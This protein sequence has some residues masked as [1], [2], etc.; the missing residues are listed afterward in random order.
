MSPLLIEEMGSALLLT[1]NRPE[2]LNALS[3]E[4]TEALLAAVK[5]AT[6]RRHIRSI[7]ITGAGTKAFSAGTDLKQRRDF[8]P[9]EKWAQS[10]S[11]WYLTEAIRSSPKA[12][13]AAVGG[14]CLGGGFELALACDLRIAADDARFAWPEM[15]LGAYPGAGAAVML[16]RLIGPAAAKELFFTAARRIDAAKAHAIGLVQAVTTREQLMETAFAYAAD[17]EH[18][19]PLGLAGIKQ[20][21]N[22]ATDL[23]WEEAVRLDQAVRRPLEGTRDYAE[24][25]QAHFEKRR[26]VFIGE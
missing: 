24:G 18:T 13:I 20:V 8:S 12:V 15:T 26:P 16:P 6:E 22:Q 2:V 7:I 23:P 3:M 1:L 9:D 11:L 10:R 19:S 14:W 4:L 17:I 5:G 21:V 25:I